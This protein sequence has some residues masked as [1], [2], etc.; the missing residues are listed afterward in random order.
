MQ[1]RITTLSC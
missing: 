1:I